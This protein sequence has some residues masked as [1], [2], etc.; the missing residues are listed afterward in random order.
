VEGELTNTADD[1]ISRIETTLL[2]YDANGKRRDLQVDD[3][4]QTTLPIPAHATRALRLPLRT[5]VLN[6]D[7]LRLG[8]SAAE[9]AT[10]VWTNVWLVADTDAA[11][12]ASAPIAPVKP[13]T[14]DRLSVIVL[15]SDDAPV[16]LLNVAVSRN[17]TGTPAVV[18]MTV[19]SR[20]PEPLALVKVDALVFDGRDVLRLQSFG[21]T[22]KPIPGFGSVSRDVV[23]N[24]ALAQ[25]DW[26]VVVAV[27]EVDAP[28]R[29]WLNE[30]LTE[31]AQASLQHGLR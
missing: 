28:T 23:V 20:V 1:P 11:V 2:V 25:P 12:V 29:K 24:R 9:T 30:N 21:R 13:V 19:R 5:A 26:K 7:Q 27:M 3:L 14:T 15:N 17:I 4:T 8:V 18:H 6:G 16:E 10:E 22:T 31:K